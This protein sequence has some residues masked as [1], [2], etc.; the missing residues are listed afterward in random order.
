MSEW[1]VP[2]PLDQPAPRKVEVDGLWIGLLC[3]STAL[4]SMP[5]ILIGVILFSQAHELKMLET[6]GVD[7]LGTVVGLQPTVIDRGRRGNH[8]PLVDYI[9][10]VMEF[11]GK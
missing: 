1:A 4:F 8:G 3:M 10:E 9:Y 7:V 2:F 5:I 11:A 6:R